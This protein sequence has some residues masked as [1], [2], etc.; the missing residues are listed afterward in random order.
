VEGAEGLG[1]IDTIKGVRV[2]DSH[3]KFDTAET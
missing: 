2:A 3:P 1:L